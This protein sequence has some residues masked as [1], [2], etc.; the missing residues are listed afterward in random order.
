MRR[1][2]ICRYGQL[3]S[4]ILAETTQEWKNINVS[5]ESGEKTAIRDSVSTLLTSIAIFFAERLYIHTSS[6]SHF[7]RPRPPN[8]YIGINGD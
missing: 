8:H 4:E 3:H 2:F 7:F 1:A 6:Q 5:V